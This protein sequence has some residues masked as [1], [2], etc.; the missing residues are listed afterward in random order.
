MHFKCVSNQC[1]LKSYVCDGTEDCYDKTDEN[2]CGIISRIRTD[3]T[4][5]WHSCADLYYPC[6]SAE[7]IP[8]T[9]ICDGKFHCQ[10]G[11]DE[12]L[13][14]TKL[15]YVQS[16]SHSDGIIST[17]VKVSIRSSHINIGYKLMV[18][19]NLYILGTH[20]NTST[21]IIMILVVIKTHKQLVNVLS[22]H[23]IVGPLAIS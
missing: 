4:D 23:T 8:L 11:S 2:G 1:I 18:C 15:R 20:N 7:C 10:D 17:T 14:P 6:I 21:A 12:V 16:V 9:L 19:K 3:S 22:M 13:C 5:R